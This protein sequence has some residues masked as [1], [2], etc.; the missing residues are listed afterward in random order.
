MFNQ[1][2][3]LYFSTIYYTAQH[4]LNLTTITSIAAQVN[5][6]KMVMYDPD[7]LIIFKN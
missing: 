4:E 3:L 5:E 1:L 6:E 2:I 7:V